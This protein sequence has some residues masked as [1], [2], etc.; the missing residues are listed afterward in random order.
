VD[1][2]LDA[3]KAG[4]RAP[5]GKIVGVIAPHAGH[6]YSGRSP[7]MPSGCA[8]TRVETVITLP[9]YFTTTGC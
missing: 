5:A 4:V 2:Y 7:H 8:R 1:G 6:K 3:A 9:E